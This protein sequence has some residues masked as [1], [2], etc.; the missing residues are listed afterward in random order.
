MTENATELAL[1]EGARRFEEQALAEIYARFSPGLY[2]YAV[3]LLD[4][5]ELAEDCVAETFSRFLHT[6][7]RGSG[8]GRFLKAYLYR[9]AH[10]WIVDHFRRSKAPTVADLPAVIDDGQPS[11]I[12]RER[13][14]REQVRVALLQ[15][16]TQQRQVIVLRY[17]EGF[18][19]EEIAATLGKSVG[20]I[21]SMQHRALA[22]LKRILQE[23]G[24]A[25]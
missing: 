22:S 21:K 14:R 24:E 13:A 25:E 18:T 19:N 11:E 7:Q 4:E 23:E 17:L 3:R 9:T 6:L 15:L 5:P 8:P 20:S 2:R 1:L 16:T 12:F 10:N